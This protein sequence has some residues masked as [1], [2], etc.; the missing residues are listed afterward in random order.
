MEMP[1][2]FWKDGKVLKLQKTLY[3]LFQVPHT[4]WKYLVEKL[5]VCGMS[6]S[7][8]DF[9]GQNVIFIHYVDDLLFWSKNEACI[10]RMANSIMSL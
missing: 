10:K 3:G 6:Q 2:G 8:L 4:F 1:W 7:K 9:I 5:E